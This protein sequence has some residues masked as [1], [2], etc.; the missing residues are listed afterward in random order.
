MRA[1][2]CLIACAASQRSTACWA[3]SQ[4]SGA[5]PKPLFRPVADLNL[6][7]LGSS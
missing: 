5:L 4:N 2:S 3:S 1:T 6:V 7:N